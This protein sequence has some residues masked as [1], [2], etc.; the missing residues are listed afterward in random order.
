MLVKRKAL[1]REQVSNLSKKVAETCHG[2]I[3]WSSATKLHIYKP[4]WGQ[5]EV[6]ASLLLEK[7]KQINPSVYIEHPGKEPLSKHQFNVIIVPCIGFDKDLYRLGFGGGWYDQFLKTQPRAKKIG[8]CYEFG[9]INKGLPHEP[10]D[11]PMDMVVT[12]NDVAK[13]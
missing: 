1:S 10:H 5:T 13:Q 2:L 12:E 7:I 6:D 3:D 11:V 4:I 8:L 9:F